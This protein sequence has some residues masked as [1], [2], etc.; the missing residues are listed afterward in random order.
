[1][2]VPSI[3]AKV[4]RPSEVRPSAGSAR[5]FSTNPV[6]GYFQR[7]WW[8]EL[9]LA[10]VFWR[11][12]AVVGTIVNVVTIGLAVLAAAVGAATGVGL[13]IFMAPTP[14]N[15]LLVASVWRRADRE[16]SDWALPARIGAL[17]WL[18]LAFLI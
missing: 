5:Q 7:L 12:M 13:I 8:A 4:D 6:I 9:P 14:Y 1:M 17:A 11:D 10:T 2:K 15:I 16:Y 18:L 3:P